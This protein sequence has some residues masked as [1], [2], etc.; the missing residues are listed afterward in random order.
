MTGWDQRERRIQE[1]QEHLERA[2][3]MFAKFLPVA[4]KY[5]KLNGIELAMTATENV[6]VYMIS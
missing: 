6:G 1:E 2:E 4:K 5:A 3:Y